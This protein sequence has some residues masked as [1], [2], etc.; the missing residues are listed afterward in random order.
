MPET[1]ENRGAPVSVLWSYAIQFV[2]DAQENWAR[3][4]L[5]CALLC[6]GVLSWVGPLADLITGTA[7]DSSPSD[8]PATLS[9]AD[10]R[11]EMPEVVVR[12]SFRDVDRNHTGADTVGHHGGTSRT[13]PVDPLVR[14]A[15]LAVVQ[16]DPFHAE[17]MPQIAA[18]NSADR[19]PASGASAGSGESAAATASGLTLQSTIVGRRRRAAIINDRLYRERETIHHRGQSYKLSAVMPGRVVLSGESG[20]LQLEIHDSSDDT[21]RSSTEP[22]HQEG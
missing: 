21:S 16:S 5:P 18:G 6:L 22:R 8:V 20:L 14:S 2:E 15:A 19:N 10:S 11:P 3:S 13:D 1:S 17:T 7:A 12:A 4:L 9:T